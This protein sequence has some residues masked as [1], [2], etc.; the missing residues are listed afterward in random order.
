MLITQKLR[1]AALWQKVRVGTDLVSAHHESVLVE[2]ITPTEPPR[3]IPPSSLLGARL[4]HGL[5]ARHISDCLREK[6]VLGGLWNAG[7][8]AL[9]SS[10][11]PTVLLASK[12]IKQ[13]PLKAGTTL[14]GSCFLHSEFWRQSVKFEGTS[15]SGRFKVPFRVS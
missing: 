12:P 7:V 10:E 9:R 3:P 15:F 5:G 4:C 6:R 8:W 1:K 13:K 11:I 2:Q 14:G